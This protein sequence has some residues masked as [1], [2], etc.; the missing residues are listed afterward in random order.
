MEVVVAP[1]SFVQFAPERRTPHHIG[2]GDRP[3]LPPIRVPYDVLPIAATREDGGP[4][5]EPCITICYP[6]IPPYLKG[7]VAVV[8]KPVLYLEQIVNQ[9]GKSLARSVPCSSRN[10]SG[11]QYLPVVR[12]RLPERSKKPTRVVLMSSS[13][14]SSSVLS[15]SVLSSSVVSCVHV[16]APSILTLLPRATSVTVPFRALILH[17]GLAAFLDPYRAK[18]GRPHLAGCSR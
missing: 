4:G 12:G 10:C 5:I 8:G 13:V 7:L 2:P 15:S 6:I 17:L 9:P 18:R 11:K 1:A 3:A 14:L 16:C